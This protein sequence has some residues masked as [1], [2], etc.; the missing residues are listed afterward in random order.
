MGMYV[1][2]SNDSFLLDSGADIYRDKTGLIK[3]LNDSLGTPQRYF[4]VSRARRFGKSQACGMIDAY[5]SVGCDSRELFS[6]FDIAKDSDFETHLN[7]D[8]VLHFDVATYLNDMNG[9]KGTVERLDK[10]LLSDF[11]KEFPEIIDNNVMNASQ[12]VRAVFEHTGRRFVIVI[13]EWD[14]IIRDA[15]DEHELIMEY[16]SYLR[17]FFKTE[18]SKRFLALGYITGI[19]PIKKF[20][21]ESAMNNFIEY[22]MPHPGDLVR[23]FGFTEEE[24]EELCK[25]KKASV[26]MV[27]EWYDGYL[28]EEA[29]EDG[30]SNFHQIHMYNPNSIVNLFIARRF[31]SF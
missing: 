1:N 27:R 5:Y 22:T 3:I 30:I 6:R 10:A 29:D 4:A 7:K 16:L 15:K 20:E 18:E 12:A 21:G 14:C 17:G 13:D 2:P 25:E 28:M 8:N 9:A 31:D 26:D 19:L 23:Y 24:M 11:K